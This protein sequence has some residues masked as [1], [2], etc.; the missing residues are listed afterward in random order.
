ML[1]LIV[2][3]LLILTGQEDHTEAMHWGSKFRDR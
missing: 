1:M 3:C 2:I